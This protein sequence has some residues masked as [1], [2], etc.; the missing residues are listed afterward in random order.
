MTPS[1]TSPVP[2]AIPPDSGQ[3]PRLL[4]P[5][6][7]QDALAGLPPDLPPDLADELLCDME[8]DTAR[9]YERAKPVKEYGDDRLDS[10]PCCRPHTPDRMIRA[11]HNAHESHQINDDGGC[12]AGDTCPID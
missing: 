2:P 10:Q 12:N 1:M 3:V 5:G 11:V 8:P 6:S 7:S 9:S 4:A